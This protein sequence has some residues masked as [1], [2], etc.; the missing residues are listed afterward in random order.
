VNAERLNI[1]NADSLEVRRLKFDLVVIYRSLH[2]L[3]ALDFSD[4]FNMTNSSTRG[5]AFELSKYFSCVDCRAF[6]FANRFIDVWN[7]LENDIVTAPSL[8]SFKCRL[9]LIL[10]SLFVL[11]NV[12]GWC[13]L[14]VCF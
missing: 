6:S 8:Y 14:S 3:N 13:K 5:H 1:L 2:G 10:I 4:F 7:S 11:R 12:Q 9:L